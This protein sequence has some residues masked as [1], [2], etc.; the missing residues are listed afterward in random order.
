ML[1]V[2]MEPH[3][4]YIQP[5]T[6]LADTLDESTSSSIC[7]TVIAPRMRAGDHVGAIDDGLHAIVDHITESGER[8]VLGGVPVSVIFAA[9]GCACFVLLLVA[10]VVLA[11]RKCNQ[12][13][14]RMRKSSQTLVPATYSNSGQGEATYSCACGNTYAELFIIAM[15]TESTSSSSSDWSSSSSSSSDGSGGGGSSW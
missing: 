5:G 10:L 13:G 8:R 9:L 1:L 15:L 14:R 7:S 3:R 6:A 4:L 12:C 11:R 2:I